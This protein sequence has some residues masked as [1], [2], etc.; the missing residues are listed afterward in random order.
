MKNLNPLC[1]PQSLGVLQPESLLGRP[2][3][4]DKSSFSSQ[5]CCIGLAL[6]NLD[7]FSFEGPCAHA[8]KNINSQD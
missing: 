5:F 6:F 1:F 4:D 7:S 8:K 3:H 2:P